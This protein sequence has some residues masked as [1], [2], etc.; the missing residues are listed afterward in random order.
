MWEAVPRGC[1]RARPAACRTLGLGPGP[2]PRHGA[3]AGRR[4]AAERCGAA[5]RIRRRAGRGPPGVSSGSA[6][7]LRLGSYGK[8]VVS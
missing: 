7:A 1:R 3:G 4:V 6:P 8:S 2:G 5:V